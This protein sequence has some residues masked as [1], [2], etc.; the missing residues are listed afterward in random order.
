MGWGDLDS[1]EEGLVLIR[2]GVLCV[3]FGFWSSRPSLGVALPR[4]A[5]TRAV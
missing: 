3:S 1:R 4:R 2:D 5:E